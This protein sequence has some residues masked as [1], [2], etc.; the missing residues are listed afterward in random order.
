MGGPA[1]AMLMDPDGGEEQVKM[2]S[3]RGD[4]GR[5]SQTPSAERSGS[6]SVA[7]KVKVMGAA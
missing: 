3:G 6:G 7:P 4:G 2:A 1:H 5:G